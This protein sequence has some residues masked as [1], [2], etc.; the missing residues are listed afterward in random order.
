MKNID[1]ILNE[2][3]DS[4]V[5]NQYKH[6]ESENIELKDNSHTGG[7]WDT[8]METVC[9]F[10]NTNNG[11]III[12]IREDEKNKKYELTGFNFNNE[13]HLKDILKEITDANNNKIEVS[14]YLKLEQKELL[15]KHLM[16][17]YVDSLPADERYVYYKRNAYE[18]IMSGDCKIHPLKIETQNEYKEEIRDARELR[19]VANAV[20]DDMDI[21]KL[22]N[23]IQLL[24]SEVKMQ[25]LLPSINDAIPFLSKNGM[26]LEKTPTILGMLVCGK[27]PVDFLHWRSQVDAYVDMPKE[28]P[29][30]K[31]VINDNILPLLEKSQAFVF[32]NIKTGISL[33]KGGTKTFEY[34]E[35]LIRECINNALAHRDY[36]I[37]QFVNINIVPGKHIEIKNPGK[38]KSQLLIINDKTDIPIRRIVP[39]AKANNPKLAKV[40]SVYNKWEGKG[41][42]MK[43]LVSDAL[44]GF[45][46]LPYYVFHSKD[47]LSL[48]IPKGKLVDDRMKLLF[49]SYSKYIKEKLNGDDLSEEQQSVFAFFYKSEMQNRNNRFTLLLTQDNN[50]L[51]A[52]NFLEAHGII[53]K[54]ICSDHIN[55]VYILDRI[56]F[57][58]DFF[59]ELRMIFGTTFD[60]LH[61]DFKH[62]LNAIYH[63]KKYSLDNAISANLIGNYLFSKQNNEVFILGV[64]ESFKRKIR[65]QFNKL[66]SAGLIKSVKGKSKT[67]ADKNTD[68]ELNIMYNS[69]LFD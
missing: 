40:L 15:N 32:M 45:I 38:F 7:L 8:F 56:F 18:R 23:Y 49:K 60:N 25:N 11:I 55:I 24:N 66:E 53:T 26:L 28:M 9:A 54:H 22:N 20:L 39:L 58:D 69:T 47:E 41:R 3:E 27:T 46:D 48:C 42:G 30:D 50:H 36:S 13:T 62:V 17:L 1:Q 65:Y 6:I 34:P 29:I 19:P 10:L 4:I 44:D 12:G 51:Q 52:I 59:A 5:N 16:V 37:N 33:K 67:G 14:S 68:Y 63:F 21:D 31:K 57:R 35:T 43:N 64:Y 61:T 2:L